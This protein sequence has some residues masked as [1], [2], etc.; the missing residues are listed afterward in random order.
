MNYQEV[1]KNAAR[2][3]V[4]FKNPHHLLRMIARFIAK[5]VHLTHASILLHDSVRNRYI[6]IDSKGELKIP[7]RLIRVDAD[8]PLIR[9]LQGKCEVRILKKDVLSLRHLDD[10][11]N[12]F[13]TSPVSKLEVQKIIDL[14]K[15]LK[16]SLCVP[17]IYRGELLGVLILGTKRS[18]GDFT[19]EEIS[20]FQT[21]AHDAA[22]TIKT[23]AYQMELLERNKQLE[24]Q[25]TEITRLRKKEQ[26]TYYQ[27]MLSLAEE[28][29]EKDDSTFGHLAAVEKL[30]VMTAE[31]MGMDLNGKKR[32]VLIAGLRLHD[33][34]KIGIPDAILKKED[35]LNQ[36]EWVIM[37]QHAA[38]GAK[39]LAPLADFKEVAE[40][41]H[42]H[43]E[44][45]DGKGY[46]RGLKGDQIPIESA[47]ISVVD[48]FHAMVSE[49]CYKKG[50]PLEFAIHELESNSGR[51][52]HPKVVEAFMSVLKTKMLGYYEARMHEIHGNNAIHERKAS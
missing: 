23:A 48:A 40:I 20:H 45:Y 9:C 25:V 19:D 10:I 42:C 2:S 7:V 35:S 37:K 18:G 38:K 12:H 24:E 33:I 39:I 28:V 30:G 5:E 1:L 3:M 29:R 51:Q 32:D 26:E 34:G 13:H 44:F 14:M 43:H 52:F 41:V 16:A 15:A 21:L 22:M 27:I 46:P 31:E 36:E 17:S 49:R 8:H 47:I 50:Y 4:R 11:L 6:F